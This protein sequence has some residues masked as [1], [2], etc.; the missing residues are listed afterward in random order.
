M[1]VI[2]FLS[3]FCDA[4]SEDR[5]R[6]RNRSSFEFVVNPSDHAPS[7]TDIYVSFDGG[8]SV[9]DLVRYVT[10]H[11]LENYTAVSS[12]HSY[13]FID[14]DDIRVDNINKEVRFI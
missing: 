8:V 7:D 11:N 3:C 9:K 13:R 14:F 1:K 10:K 4:T 6:T 5:I 12:I 2:D